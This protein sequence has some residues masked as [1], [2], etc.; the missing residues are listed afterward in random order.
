MAIIGALIGVILL[1]III[2][3]VY[4]CI[5]QLMPLL[6]LPEP[7]RRIVNVLLILIL[8]LIVI[9]VILLLLSAVG[10]HVPLLGFR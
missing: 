7:F 5:D 8:A 2:G 9:Y 6:P 4:Y 10:I 3:V 1:I